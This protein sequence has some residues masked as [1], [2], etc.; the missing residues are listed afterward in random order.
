[1]FT[2]TVGILGG[3][4]PSPIINLKNIVK[5]YYIRWWY[6]GVRFRSTLLMERVIDIFI[7]EGV[8]FS[9]PQVGKELDYPKRAYSL[10]S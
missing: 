6:E 5:T 7:R 10:I 4:N 9:L 1:M 2:C 8:W 3:P